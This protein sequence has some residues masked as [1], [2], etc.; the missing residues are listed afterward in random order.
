MKHYVIYEKATGAILMNGFVG[1]L[2][3]VA[4]HA[5]TH[6]IIETDG[7]ITSD[8]HY[9]VDGKAVAKGA[10]GATCDKTSVA[11]NGTDLVTIGG[12]PVPCTLVLNG[13]RTGLYYVTD[14]VV[15]LTFQVKG[16]Y[17]V[18][19]FSITELFKEFVI[20]AN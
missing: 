16:D 3:S 8:T 19:I 6:E 17:K 13:P 2:S 1:A 4:P 20:H 12:L 7:T 11:A 14:G 9:V 5:D 15:E 18:E 10:S